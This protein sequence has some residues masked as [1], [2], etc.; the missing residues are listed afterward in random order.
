MDYCKSI[1]HSKKEKQSIL[2]S[3]DTKQQAVQLLVFF[4]KTMRVSKKKEMAKFQHF[5]S[6]FGCFIRSLWFFIRNSRR[7]IRTEFFI[8]SFKSFIRNSLVLY[9]ILSFYSQIE[10]V[11]SIGTFYSKFQAFYSKFACF[12]RNLELLFT[13]RGGLFDRHTFI[14]KFVFLF[15]IRLLLFEQHPLLRS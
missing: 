5:Y 11:Y 9:E 3:E 8:Q 7:F 2:K 4:V 1:F 10:V 15:E 6:M 14:R 12:I 13:N